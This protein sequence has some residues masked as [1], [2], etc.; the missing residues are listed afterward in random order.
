MKITAR[1]IDVAARALIDLFGEDAPNR[2]LGMVN[3]KRVL[4]ESE[5]QAF[6]EQLET[7][8]REILAAK[9]DPNAEVAS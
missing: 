6:W 1:E 3:E 8:I 5:S 9:D 2:A 7:R 4:G